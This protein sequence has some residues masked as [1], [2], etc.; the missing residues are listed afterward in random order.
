MTLERYMPRPQDVVDAAHEASGLYGIA[1]GD[2]AKETG[3]PLTAVLDVVEHGRGTVSDV[4][5]VLDALGINPSAIPGPK[6]LR[7]GNLT[8]DGE[9]DD[10]RDCVELSGRGAPRHDGDPASVAYVTGD[11]HGGAGEAGCRLAASRWPAGRTLTRTDYVIVCGDFG[12]VWDGGSRDRWWLDWL[13]RRSWTTLFV[14]G[15]HENFDLL[16]RYPTETWHG[17]LTHV[18]RPHVRHLMRGQVYEDIAGTRILAMGGAASH[19]KQWREEGVS[20]WPEEMPSEDDFGE[21]RRNLD[22]CGWQVDYVITHDAPASVADRL[23]YERGREG[24]PAGDPLQDFLEEIYRRLEY[25]RWYFGHYHGDLD[26]EDAMDMTLL[27][28]GIVRLGEDVG[29]EG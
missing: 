6:A 3:L 20:W 8:D 27:F 18:V 1:A 2:V 4:M 16:D 13:E 23:M 26:V 7:E 14:D 10:R 12:Y 17:G 24:D 21:C 19:D 29:E 15:N 5:D 22:A 28:H 11:M 9:E 25:K